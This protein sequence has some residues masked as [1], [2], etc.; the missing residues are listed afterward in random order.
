MV[1]AFSVISIMKKE[2]TVEGSVVSVECISIGKSQ[3]AIELMIISKSN[4]KQ[5]FTFSFKRTVCSDAIREFS[6]NDDVKIVYGSF[7]GRFIDVRELYLN[8]RKII[9]L[10]DD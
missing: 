5:R 1:I 6:F 9:L 3:T 2:K 8:G 7:N 4:K 10:S